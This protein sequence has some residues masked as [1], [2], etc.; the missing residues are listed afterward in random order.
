MQKQSSLMGKQSSRKATLMNRIF[1]VVASIV[2]GCSLFSLGGCQTDQSKEADFSNAGEVAKLATFE[3]TYHSV[4][5]IERESDKAWFIDLQNG[6]QEWFEYDAT[7]DFG[8][9]ASRVD[10]SKPNDDGEVTIAIPQG[11]VL[12]TPNIK[13]DS[14]SDPLDANGFFASITDDERKT[15]LTK[16]QQDTFE[17]A[18]SDDAMIAAARE[19]AKTLLE[20]YVKNVGEN[21]GRA[22][23]VKLVD[24]E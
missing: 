7:V 9:D 20:Q 13:A 21:L 11:Q 22:Y 10:I 18:C 2:L 23:R 4:A 3:C 14:M 16:A 19:R 6:K 5:K 1:A 17:R 15:A 24:A 8:I 12:A